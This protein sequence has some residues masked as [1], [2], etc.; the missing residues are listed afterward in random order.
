MSR[1]YLRPFLAAEPLFAELLD[2]YSAVLPYDGNLRYELIQRDFLPSTAEGLVGIFRRSAEFAQTFDQRPN[3][4]PMP[5]PI[6]V[7]DETGAAAQSVKSDPVA[8][9]RA[10]PQM[11]DQMREGSGHDRIPVRLAG[12]RRAWLLIPHEFR[13]A[14]KTRLKAQIDLLLTEDEEL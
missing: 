11:D 10:Q 13:E 9:Y 1:A 4:E 2:R 5:Q 7:D 8:N 14:D 12:G 6:E 3:G